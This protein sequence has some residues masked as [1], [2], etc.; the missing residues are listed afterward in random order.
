MAF[1]KDDGGEEEAEAEVEIWLFLHSRPR[2]QVVRCTKDLSQSKEKCQ[3]GWAANNDQ[4]SEDV[5][6]DK[7]V[8]RKNA[9]LWWSCSYLPPSALKYTRILNLH[10]DFWVQLNYRP[11]FRG[12]RIILWGQRYSSLAEHLPSMCW[13]IGSIFSIA[14]GGESLF[15]GCQ[16]LLIPWAE[17][18]SFGTVEVQTT[19]IQSPVAWHVGP[20]CPSV[21]T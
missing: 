3:D 2:W 7:A 14:R 9:L 1:R 11:C 15:E 20:R 16:F 21:S 17:A 10:T 6:G 4:G 8:E 12:I 13:A 18:L 5:C 19:I